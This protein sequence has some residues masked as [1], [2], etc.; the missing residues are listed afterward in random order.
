MHLISLK[1]R[2]RAE[3]FRSH[4]KPDDRFVVGF[5]PSTTAQLWSEKHGD[6]RPRRVKLDQEV[7]GTLVGGRSWRQTIR[8]YLLIHDAYGALAAISIAVV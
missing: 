6:C 7:E 1:T 4:V 8:Q 2:R 3:P 5:F